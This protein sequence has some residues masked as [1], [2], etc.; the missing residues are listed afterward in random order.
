MFRETSPVFEVPEI[1]SLRKVKPLPKRRRMADPTYGLGDFSLSPSLDDTAATEL[2]NELSMPGQFPTAMDIQDYFVST[3]FGTPDLSKRDYELQNLGNSDYS[4]P[5]GFG[6]REEEEQADTDYVDHL[7]QT[8][9]TKKRKEGGEL[10]SSESLD[11]SAE[12]P[13]EGHTLSLTD[14]PSGTAG[15][16]INTTPRY[17]KISAIARAGIQRKELV[18]N[19]RKQLTNVLGVLSHNDAMALDQALSSQYPFSNL[20]ITGDSNT[21]SKE[22]PSKRLA[23][24][25]GRVK[26]RAFSS[27]MAATW[28]GDEP[29]A[30]PQCDFTFVCASATANRLIG[31]RD[32][33]A[34]LQSR[35]EG[36][37]QR[38]RQAAKLAAAAHAQK[39]STAKK[40]TG[41]LDET[42]S[43]SANASGE[44][45]TNGSPLTTSNA[46]RAKGSKKKKRSALANASNP[47]HLK[48]YVPSRLPHSAS[49]NAAAAQAAANA[50]NLL[51][52]LPISFLSADVAPRRNKKAG[53]AVSNP[54]SAQLTSPHEEWICAFCEYDL[55]YGQETNFR[56]AVR[57]RKKILGRRR[58]AREKAAATASGVK[59]NKTPV[60]APA[61]D[62][63][64][65]GEGDEGEVY[66]RDGDE[67]A[68]EGGVGG[69]RREREKVLT[70]GTNTVH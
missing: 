24:R 45:Q 33:V 25:T 38:Q 10:D 18:K 12:P 6:E 57:S 4:S 2:S 13:G 60:A 32:E 23:R 59:K 69:G 3:A 70:G 52:P 15:A 62:G 5:P 42:A 41:R 53:T 31:I 68:S 39:E 49:S 40:A 27:L 47:H 7:Q 22:R 19:R 30:F 21:Q 44:A 48:N 8:G 54:P 20:S 9:N 17:N 51:W 46:T 58:R 28:E 66:V 14:D 34:A 56:K 43:A 67:E 61:V 65:E 29:M 1:A 35:F 63:E 37:L 64:D 26:G 50:Q 16:L 55:F 36:E 11:P